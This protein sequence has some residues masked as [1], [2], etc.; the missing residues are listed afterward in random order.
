DLL[1]YRVG[2]STACEGDR[3]A[4]V[5]LQSGPNGEVPVPDGEEHPVKHRGFIQ[6]A[7]VWAHRG[8]EPGPHLT[9]ICKGKGAL[10]KADGRACE[11]GLVQPSPDF[12]VPQSPQL[13]PVKEGRSD[14]LLSCSVVCGAYCG[15]W[16]MRAEVMDDLV[17]DGQSR[18]FHWMKWVVAAHRAPQ[19]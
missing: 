5:H 18:T 8:H 15:L 1:E 6:N 3:G 19:D 16:H 14:G 17:S 11:E 4:R 2:Q 10:E 13:W 7:A 12:T 9:C